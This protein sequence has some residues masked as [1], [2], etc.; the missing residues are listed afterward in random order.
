MSL[1]ARNRALPRSV[2]EFVNVTAD[3]DERSTRTLLLHS[4]RRVLERIKSG[5]P[6]EDTLEMLVRLLEE[7]ANGMRC[8]VLLTDPPQQRLRFVAAPSIP[9]DYK[10]C[11]DPHL[12]IAPNTGSCGTAAFLREPVYTDDIAT[13][14][15]WEACRGCAV[16]NGLR[17]IWSTP[18]LSDDNEVLGTFAMFYAEPRLPSAEDK[19][20]IDMATQLARVAIETKSGEKLL[21]TI[22]EGAPGGISIA[23]LT[24]TI[25]RVNPAFSRLLGYTENELQKKN[26]AD[27]T[28]EDDYPHCQ[29]LIEEL[30]AGKR[31]RFVIEKRYRRKDGKLVWV[32]NIVALLRGPA[33]EPRSMIALS[34]DITDLKQ[35]EDELR[36]SAV[37]LRTLSRRLVEVQESERKELSR[38]LHD[39]VGQNL[40]ALGI[41]LAILRTQLV[42]DRSAELQS[43]LQDSEALVVSTADAIDDVMTELRPPLLNEYGLLPAL[44]WYA[45]QFSKRAGIDVTVT[46][47]EPVERPAASIDIALF[48]IAQE[49]LNNVAKHARATRVDVTVQR[50]RTEC[51]MTIS[52]DGTGFDVANYANARST[53]RRGMVTM[54]ERAQV[55]GGQFEVVSDRGRGT[56]VTVRIPC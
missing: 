22:F 8:A 18:I 15:L 19:Q 33:G 31:E 20:L 14:P 7:Q 30:L 26:I 32:H 48:R 12:R 56:R 25:E 10:S 47:D 36:L 39:R 34:E 17:A 51:I 2:A 28:Y 13:D 43:R 41:H 5:A 49:A 45:K 37:Q 3:T 42:G 44:D 24:G 16:R 9:E 1:D 40:T 53:D 46:G 4:Q 23:D 52:D 29:V 50:L 21:H 35:A 27:V 55:V 11:I 54:R 6:L 38:E